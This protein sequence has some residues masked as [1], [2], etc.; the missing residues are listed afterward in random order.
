MNLHS[1]KNLKRLFN[2][3][4][5]KWAWSGYV[6]YVINSWETDT[7][8]NIWRSKL[9]FVQKLKKKIKLI[10]FLKNSIISLWKKIVVLLKEYVRRT[11]R[12]QLLDSQKINRRLSFSVACILSFNFT[13]LMK[14]G[15]TILSLFNSLKSCRPF[16]Q[17]QCCLGTIHNCS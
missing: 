7:M 3:C 14:F 6:M 13:Y 17:S 16:I 4:W 1:V 15:S 11:K 2:S 12:A 5:W 9:N 10:I 8:R